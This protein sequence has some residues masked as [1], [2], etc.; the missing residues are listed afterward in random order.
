[1]GQPADGVRVKKADVLFH[2][3]F[4]ATG[5]GHG[6]DRALVA[7]LMGFGVD[8]PR[9]AASFRYA[10]EAGMASPAKLSL[11]GFTC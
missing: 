4:L 3:S 7:G 8:D 9:I 10:K 1:M 11:S 6:T 2:G 5:K